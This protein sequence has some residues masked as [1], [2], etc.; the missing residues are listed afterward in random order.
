MERDGNYDV[1]A[2]GQRQFA[3]PEIQRARGRP[4]G[5][6]HTCAAGSA[7]A[8]CRARPRRQDGSG[9][10]RRRRRNGAASRRIASIA[11]R[12]RWR[13]RANRRRSRIGIRAAAPAGPYRPRTRGASSPGQGERRTRRIGGD[14]GNSRAKRA[15]PHHIVD[16]CGAKLKPAIV[17]QSC[18]ILHGAS[19]AKGVGRCHLAVRSRIARRCGNC[20]RDTALRS[21]TDGTTTGSPV[22][23]RMA[24]SKARASDAAPAATG[25][26]SS[27]RAYQESLGGA[28]SLH[29]VANLS[30]EIN[31]DTAVG[32]AYFLY[33]HCK[34]GR[35]QQAAVGIYI[36]QLRR[37]PAGWRF[38]SRHV[39]ICG[40]NCKSGPG[41]P[42]ARS[43]GPGFFR[44]TD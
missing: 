41:F 11:R 19:L 32:S 22:S 6:G 27:A 44:R 35:V 13:N 33:N 21:T 29:V 30:L 25:S 12:R 38:S 17:A 5:P 7:G 34:E 40:H 8:G 31:G 42:K 43:Q 16:A 26:A 3:M 1:V 18:D 23:P 24:S 4:I 2:G 15:R 36:D 10:G 14:R 20:T 9:R 37:T 39:T 28:H